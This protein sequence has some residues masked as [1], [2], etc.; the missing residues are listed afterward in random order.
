ML[1]GST[2]THRSWGHVPCSGIVAS[3]LCVAVKGDKS[4]AT[5]SHESTTPTGLRERPTRIHWIALAILTVGSILVRIWLNQQIEAPTIL[6]DELTYSQLAENI[7]NGDFSLSTGYGFVYPLLLAPSWALADFGTT[8]YTY[9]QTTNAIVVSL[10]A[11]PVFLWAKRMM[12]PSYAL[13]AAALTLAMPSMAY[14]GMIMTD[15]AFLT[16]FVLAC[17]AIAVAAERPT[18]LNQAFVVAALLLAM[19]TRAQ[20]VVLFAALPIIFLLTIVM[21]ERATGSFSPAGLA[22]RALRF[23]PLAT[24][25]GVGLVAVVVRTALTSWHLSDVLQAYG[26]VTTGQYNAMT[27]A[28]YAIWHAGD[29]SLAVGIIPVSA[30]LVMVGLAILNRSQSASERAYLSTALVASVLVIIQVATFTSWFSQRVSERNM[31]CIFPLIFLGM[32]LW[33]S[34]ALPRPRRVTGV[35]AA[36]AGGLVFVIPFGYLYQRSPSTETWA[37]VLP[38]FLA[39]HLKAG[40]DDVAILIAIGVAAALLVFGIV[41]PRLALYLA[42]VLLIGYFVISQIVILHTLH[43]VSADYRKFSSLGGNADWLDRALPA[44]GDVLFFTGSSLGTSADQIALWETGFFNRDQFTSAPWGANIKFVAPTGAL[45]KPDGS[46][47]ELPKYVVTPASV[48]LAGRVLTGRGA[49]ILQE[50][51]KPYRMLRTTS[52]FSF[53]GWSAPTATID[54]YVNDPKASTITLSLSRAVSGAQAPTTGVTVTIGKL[55]S[56]PGGTAGTSNPTATKTV[57]VMSATTTV[58]LT[59]PA[60]PFRITVLTETPFTLSS[61]GIPDSRQLGVRVAATYAGGVITQ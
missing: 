53:D 30:A 51:T 19:G 6:T 13:L 55:F 43:K 36:I 47:L 27:V 41:K 12:R 52:G 11:I 14:S 1:R 2:P 7:A 32:A 10:V 23:W 22:R 4:R 21:E 50:P 59:V 45:T 35:A 44:G 26:S 46:L 31:Y 3:V 48:Q 42:P 37:I 33:L 5:M 38:D 39:R 58:T 49:F 40:G 61:L 15:N 8:A 24:L 18:I 34:Q 56:L 54:M 9:M 29:A 28:R 25:A 20:A 17:F 60:A 16:V 57:S